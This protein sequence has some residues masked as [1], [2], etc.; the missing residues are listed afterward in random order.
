MHIFEALQTPPKFHEKPPQ[1]EERIKKLTGRGKKSAKFWASHPSGLHPSDPTRRL[2]APLSS[3]VLGPSFGVPLSGP[4]LPANEHMNNARKRSKKTKQ[5]TKKLKQL[6]LP[7]NKPFQTTKTLS[8][9]QVGLAKVGLAKVGLSFCAASTTLTEC[10][11]G[12]C[13]TSKIPELC[14]ASCSTPTSSQAS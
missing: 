14:A 11:N 12:C 2:S 9:V 6:T 4:T 13:E 8:L 3:G 5:I 1:R 10:P 7:K